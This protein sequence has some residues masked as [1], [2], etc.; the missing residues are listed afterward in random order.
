MR[1]RIRK[2]ITRARV[3]LMYA[4]PADQIVSALDNQTNKNIRLFKYR[5]R[6]RRRRRVVRVQGR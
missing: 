2:I 3:V 4:L 1:T 5:S 6:R